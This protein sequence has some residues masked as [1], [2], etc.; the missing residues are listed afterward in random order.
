MKVCIHVSAHRA[1]RKELAFKIGCK[2]QWS[3]SKQN[4]G[5]E[6]HGV[7]ILFPFFNDDSSGNSTEHLQQMGRILGYDYVQKGT[8]EKRTDLMK[9]KVDKKCEQYAFFFIAHAVVQDF[10]KYPDHLYSS[11]NTTD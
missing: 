9:N 8:Q 1:L 6:G 2:N 11:F 3:I 7:K 4:A 10:V 5:F